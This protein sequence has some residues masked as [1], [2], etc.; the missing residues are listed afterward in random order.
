MKKGLLF[1]F[2]ACLLFT[3]FSVVHAQSTWNNVYT[4]MQA[5]CSGCHG[6]ASPAGNLDLSGS[7]SVVYADLVNQVPTNP[8]AAAKGNMLVDPGYPERSFLLR[9]CATPGWDSWFEYDLDQAE[10]GR[11]PEAPQATLPDAEIE[12]IRQWILYGAS[13][14]DTVVDPTL[15]ADYY[16]GLG[17]AKVPPPA[18][19]PAG[20]GFQVR[21]GSFFL[22]P[23]G[24]IE[25]FKKQSLNLPADLEVTKIEVEFNTQ[26]HHFILYKFGGNGG[27]SYDEGLRDESEGESSAFDANIVA[28]WQNPD[29]IELPATTAYKWGAN[30]VL[31]MNYHL[32]NYSQDSIL[33]ADVYMNVYT[34]PSGIATQEM[35]SQLIP[36]DWWSTFLGGPP[37]PSLVIPNDG[38]SHR[39]SESYFGPQ[40]GSE[41]Y[42]WLMGSHTHSRGEDF[43]IY[44]RDFSGSKGDQI[45]E[46]HYNTNY[47]FN[48]GFYD[49]EHPPVRYFDP[50]LQVNLLSGLIFEAEYVNNTANTLRWGSTTKDEMMLMFV[51]FTNSQLTGVEEAGTIDEAFFQVAPNP[52]QDRTR[53]AFHLKESAEINLTVLDVLGREIQTLAEGKLGLGVH[54]YQ[55]DASQLPKG[56]YLVRF[57]MNGQSITKKVVHTE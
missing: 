38:N 48:Q 9:K 23:Q 28:A 43:D 2:T 26:S 21:L 20:Q 22:E 25:F 1:C 46:G 17:L 56:I 50:L 24:E 53:V 47:T 11:M 37:G 8:A 45:Y 40:L 13:E 51:Q 12:M 49:W 44:M 33:A 55:F 4:V 14:T 42:V 3:G 34:Q 36:I 30:D 16:N 32:L 52:F 31:D 27:S 6:G 29:P 19:P 35:R 54:E 41:W 39:F 10:G 5:K 18:A 15:I 57:E 7:M